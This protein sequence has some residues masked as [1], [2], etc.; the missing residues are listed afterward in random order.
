MSILG[1][2]EQTNSHLTTAVG[3]GQP[4]PLKLPHLC[5]S[6]LPGLDPAPSPCAQTPLSNPT[7]PA[8]PALPSTFS[9]SSIFVT[10]IVIA[11]F[12]FI[13]YGLRALQRQ[14]HSIYLK[15]NPMP[16]REHRAWSRAGTQ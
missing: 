3:P 1:R 2:E 8:P 7:P 16:S 5:P 6:L 4:H 14:A 13:S 15:V 9:I 10:F 12:P 11:Y